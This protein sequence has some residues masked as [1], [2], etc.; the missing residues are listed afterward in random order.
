[1]QEGLEHPTILNGCY[2]SPISHHPVPG[3]LRARVGRQPAQ[4]NL[5]F[6]FL[7]ISSCILCSGETESDPGMR[8]IEKSVDWE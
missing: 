1:M 5:V 8:H 7:V 2:E 4:D 3:S 6:E